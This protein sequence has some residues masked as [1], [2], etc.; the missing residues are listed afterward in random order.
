M[1][2]SKE[3]IKLAKEWRP[4]DYGYTMKLFVK[5]LE[6]MLKYYEEGKDVQQTD[7]SANEIKDTLK[8]AIGLWKTA[9]EYEYSEYDR[10]EKLYSESA[11]PKELKEFWDKEEKL[12]KEKYDDFFLY[13]SNNFRKWWD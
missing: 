10:R 6:E 8:E 1:R 7:E 2:K 9:E 11:T 12:E 4:Y 5:C 13:V 3:I